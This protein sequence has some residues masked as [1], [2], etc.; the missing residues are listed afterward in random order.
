[1]FCQSARSQILG[2]GIL[3]HCHIHTKLCDVSLSLCLQTIMQ[4]FQVGSKSTAA[5]HL[6]PSTQLLSHTHISCSALPMCNIS[7]KPAY[8]SKNAD[9]LRFPSKP[10]PPDTLR[11][12]FFRTHPS[13][14]ELFPSREFALHP[15]ISMHGGN[16]RLHIT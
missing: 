11:H 16:M 7:A 14:A 3:I 15:L 2:A 13:L 12:S 10:A 8:R 6:Y 9:T 4:T 5:R 1:M